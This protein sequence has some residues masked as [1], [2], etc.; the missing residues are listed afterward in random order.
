MKKILFISLILLQTFAYA[1][2]SKEEIKPVMS[3]KI[4]KA[5][6]IIQNKEPQLQSKIEN[7]FDEVFDYPFMAKLS[8][9]KTQHNKL[10]DAQKKEF[11]TK[12]E[13]RLKDI[14]FE[15]LKS[16]NNEKIKILDVKDVKKRKILYT[17]IVKPDK[18]YEVDYKFYN[19]GE[20]GWLI[21]DVDI[22][23]VSTIKTYRN[24]F[25]RVLID[26]DFDKL[27]ELLKKADIKK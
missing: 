23:G 2:L 4:N 8:L 26:A 17:Q 7:I 14:F 24:Q 27:L 6:Q 16:Y 19:N 25:D 22:V 12:F 1:K 20:K 15:N 3:E 13:Q 10:T 5:L 18:V 9:G 11:A 21:Y